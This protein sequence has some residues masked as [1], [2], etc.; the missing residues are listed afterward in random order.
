MA[1]QIQF[2]DPDQA[3]DDGL[4][5][6]GG[7]LSP[8]FL[9][10]AYSQGVFPWFNEGEPILWWSPNPRMVILPGKFKCSKSLMQTLRS[11]KFKI[12]MDQNFEDVIRK[13]SAI[14]RPGQQGSWITN[15]M[16]E[17]YI[18]MHEEGWAHSVEVYLDEVLVG[19]LYGISMGKAF[20]GESM[21]HL[22]RDASKVALYYLVGLAV[23]WDFHFIDAQQSTAHLKS[24]GAEDMPRHEFLKL[25][26]KSLEYPSIQGKW[27]I[28]I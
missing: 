12:S 20:F 1:V 16:I 5:A 23:K 7:S 15:D 6:V 9:L 26:V 13:C 8:D 24:L 19:G 2:P 28:N 10:A 22:V 18:K 25:L 14:K 21:F 17:A 4:V 11:G 27:D 3:D